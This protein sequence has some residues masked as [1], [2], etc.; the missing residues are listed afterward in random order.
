MFI[1][2][3]K[4]PRELDNLRGSLVEEQKKPEY[5]RYDPLNNFQ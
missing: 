4:R 1:Y 2:S 3:I 5:Y